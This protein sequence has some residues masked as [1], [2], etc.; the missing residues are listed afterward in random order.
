MWTDLTGIDGRSKSQDDEDKCGGL[1]GVPTTIFTSGVLAL[2]QGELG[3]RYMP[4]APFSEIAVFEG[5]RMGIGM[6]GPHLVNL[7]KE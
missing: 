7:R 6:M 1:S 2:A 5:V 3:V 4:L